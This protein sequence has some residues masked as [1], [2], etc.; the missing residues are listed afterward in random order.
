MGVAGA[1]HKCQCSAQEWPGRMTGQA[2]RRA[3]PHLGSSILQGLR[4]SRKAG[5][6]ALSLSSFLSSHTMEI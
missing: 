2:V 6:T 5:V 3:L 1:I 4:L